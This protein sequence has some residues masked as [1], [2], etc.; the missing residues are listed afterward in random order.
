[1]WFDEALSPATFLYATGLT[2][3]GAGVAGVIPA[4]KVTGRRVALRLR[5]A[6]AGGGGLRFGGIWTAVIVIQVAATVAFPATAWFVRRSVVAAR[7]L[8]PGF[9][10]GQ[11]L[12]AELEMDPE[13]PA[14]SSPADIRAVF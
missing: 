1:F 13:F 3:L 4:L 5:Q 12:S 6:T 7:S 14:V 10:A 8:D 9:P 11:Y 2:A